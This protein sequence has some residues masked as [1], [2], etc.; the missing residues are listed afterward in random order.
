MYASFREW[1]VKT[2]K[3]YQ[4]GIQSTLFQAKKKYVSSVGYPDKSFGL[5]ASYLI[6]KPAV[7]YKMKK[8]TG[9][10]ILA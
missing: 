10:N 8:A 4:F 1:N 9:E 6:I 5:F 3:F 7:S 2:L